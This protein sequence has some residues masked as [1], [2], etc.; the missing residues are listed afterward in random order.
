[1]RR[2]FFLSLISSLTLSVSAQAEFQTINV[3]KSVRDYNLKVDL[4]TPLD[5]YLSMQ[6][7]VTTGKQS[8]WGAI[9]S[10]KHRYVMPKADAQNRQVSARQ[11]EAELHYSV[12]KIITY[13]DSVAAVLAFNNSEEDPFYIIYWCAL[14]DG[15]WVNYGQD[16]TDD[17]ESARSKVNQNAPLFF[18][19]RDRVLKLKQP[20]GD[21]SLMADYLT[22][23]GQQPK[24]YLLKT[25]AN[26]KI[27]IY[28]EFHRRTW[29]W[30]LMKTVIKDPQFAATVGTVFMELPSHRQPLMDQ[31]YAAKKMDRELLLDVFRDEQVYG[32]FDA[33]E[34]EFLVELWKINQTLPLSK[35]I[36]VVNVDYQT[37]Y[38]EVATLEMFEN[39]PGAIDRNLAMAN[40]IEQNV[41]NSS[42][43]RN[44][45][46]IVGMA[47]AWKS[48]V[49]GTASTPRG[50]QRQ[51]TAAALLTQRFGY[52]NVFSIFQHIAPTSNGGEPSGLIRAGAFDR[53]FTKPIAFDL[54]NSP[55]GAEP[56]DGIPE[57]TYDAA[58]GSFADN[59]D[60]Y[61]FLGPLADEGDECL[62]YEIFSD[63][64]VTELKRRAAYLKMQPTDTWHG[65]RIEDLSPKALIESL[66][67][68]N[69]PR[70]RENLSQ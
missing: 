53:I 55:F 30:D 21:Q 65:V 26:R 67:S 68:E 28:G 59:Y 44:N 11:R 19:T 35:R 49:P 40:V 47:H 46:F 50:H 37:P 32:W 29:S 7:I 52:E 2:L 25:L 22:R 69:A 17:L 48:Q 9:S 13:R 14:E 42:D 38:S 33:G 36:R 39:Y 58:A 51:L 31:F 10:F 61:I 43:K 4:S 64:F 18:S 15:K 23:K 8:L 54:K 57:I 12:S 66:K 5:S 41:R 34:F 3:S 56:F 62:L 1:M 70:W 27:V 24:E 6:Y 16:M 63:R 60:G 20:S 45:L